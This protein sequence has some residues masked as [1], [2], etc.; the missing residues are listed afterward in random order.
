M[1]KGPSF[2]N[3]F[4]SR[5]FSCSRFINPRGPDNLGSCIVFVMLQNN[6]QHSIKLYITEL[7]LNVY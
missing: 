2:P 7:S 5:L 1:E 6:I 4:P 3:K